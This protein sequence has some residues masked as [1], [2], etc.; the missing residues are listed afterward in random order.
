[1]WVCSNID[2]TGSFR[3]NAVRLKAYIDDRMGSV[4]EHIGYRPAM[5][6]IIAHSMGGLIARDYMHGLDPPNA[7]LVDKVIMLAT[8]NKGVR[9]A[10][11]AKM[12]SPTGWGQWTPWAPDQ[13]AW[14]DLTT[15][16]VDDMTA[17]WGDAH[18]GC[19]ASSP[20][21]YLVAGKLLRT[22]RRTDGLVR[23]GSVFGIDAC[24][25]YSAMGAGHFSIHDSESVL[26]DYIIPVLS[27]NPPPDRGGASSDESAVDEAAVLAVAGDSLE[28][29]RFSESAVWVD[30]GVDTVS[31]TSLWFGG[32]LFLTCRSPSGVLVD[33]L[34]A[35][36]DPSMNFIRGEGDSGGSE[37]FTIQDPE[38]GE[39]H[40]RVECHEESG[41]VMV[42]T[43]GASLV[44][45]LPSVPEDP[46]VAGT[47]VTIALSLTEA[48]APLSGASCMAWLRAPSAAV[49]S[50]ALY[51][52]GQH[53][54]GAAGDGGYANSYSVGGGDGVYTVG[55]EAAGEAPVSGQF[56]R[57]ESRAFTA[58]DH[59]PPTVRVLSPNGG[60]ELIGGA[61][62]TLRW[63]AEDTGVVD[64]S[65]VIL[66]YDNGS[67]YP[68]TLA[69]FSD[70]DPPPDS[71]Y[72]W[73]VPDDYQTRCRLAVLAR[74]CSGNW[75]SDISDATWSV[76]P[77]T[78]VPADEPLALS[79]LPRLFQ[80]V[81]NPFN[82]VT[83]IAFETPAAARSAT[84]TIHNLRGAAVREWSWASPAPGVHHVNWDSTDGRGRRVGSGVYFYRLQIDEWSD[85]KK[86][87]ILK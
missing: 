21:Y 71:T 26:A 81:P 76:V 12:I 7:H 8:P 6:N 9:L 47:T 49:D 2:P 13:T 53:E 78:G 31:F 50:L 25:K 59:T 85:L 84:L 34:Y 28:A 48:D 83:T 58:G 18:T 55:F 19:D 36:Q 27:G 72:V 86:M 68:D 45:L 23:A 60:E 69:R 87:V 64:Y 33:S 24:G 52:D 17:E 15:W 30:A 74:D 14:G 65:E 10:N 42:C 37:T 57:L 1:M 5:V 62:C 80:N 44:T 43:L 20:E 56:R 79:G 40:L 51:D 63:L 38:P 32:D 70:P 66:S 75:G 39:W 77:S 41:W 22:F 54:D 35:H 11:L 67:T 29:G 82:P 73:T 3:D 16:N 46:V 4:Q 61:Q